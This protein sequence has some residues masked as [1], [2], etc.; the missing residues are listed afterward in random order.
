MEAIEWQTEKEACLLYG[1]RL[2]VLKSK[3]DIFSHIITH[4]DC[5][6]KHTYLRES[7]IE[8]SGI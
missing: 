5:S 1:T 4:R 3:L 2:L 7:P 6:P 8:Y